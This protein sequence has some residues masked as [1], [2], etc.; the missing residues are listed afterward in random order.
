LSVPHVARA[1]GTLAGTQLIN[2]YGPT[3]NT[4]FTC[5]HRITAPLPLNCSIPVGRPV[6]NT[7]VYILD[8]HFQPVPI[9]VPG[10]LFIGG[11]GL[12]R[13]YLHRPKLTAEKFISD[14]FNSQSGACLYRTGD[15]VRW[16]PDGTIEFLGRID[17]QVKIRGFR[18]E[19]EEIEVVLAQNPE[20]KETVVLAREDHNRERQLVAYV[21]A[22]RQ[23]V[24]VISELR[25]FL[26]QKL[27]DYMVPSAFVFLDAL[28]L[29][30]NGKVDR[31][32]LPAP[33]PSREPVR[34]FTAP[35]DEVEN[36]LVGI[37]ET[38]LNVRPVGVHDNF[39]ELGGHSLAAVRLITQIGKSF[40]KNLPVAT[41][42]QTPTIERLAGLLRENRTSITCSS[43]VAIEPKGSKPP[44]FFIHGAGG[45]NLWTYAN[46]APHL[47]PDQPIYG[48]ESRGMR[49][50]E[51]FER[52]EEMAAH[53][54]EEI[55]TVQPRGPYYLG[56]YCFGGNVAY[57]VARQLRAQNE[58][59]ALLA[60][61]DSAPSN[62]GYG[63]I[64]WWRPS[65]VFNFA[66]NTFFWLTDFL[67]LKPDE[68]RN[69][70]H[71]KFRV[72]KKRV[73]LRMGRK[74]TEPQL[75]DLEDVIDVE[76]F[77]EIEL[78]LWNVHLRALRDYVSLPYP[79]RVTL[80]RTRGQPF[81]CSFDP[82][83]G[84][85]GLAAGGVDVVSIPGSHEKIFLEPHVRALARELKARL[86]AT[87]TRIQTQSH[88]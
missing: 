22:A 43:L 30:P 68:R 15:R 49:G 70:I 66:V 71:R 46:L 13:G 62:A 86:N 59:V 28:P 9:G 74:I 38:V 21:V 32:A 41:I 72:L 27:P 73:L 51:E 6:S 10:E 69:F 61:L 36:R 35:R 7:R 52:I 19:L 54:I 11:D 26:Q 23:P 2:G 12:A 4:T 77:P 44:V 18:I 67:E 34:V 80:F 78:K 45:G 29:N 60:L 84:W 63:R 64:P 5:C 53:Y 42:F 20:V 16:L 75:I 14:P 8:A 37:W 85:G 3:E 1:L 56:G 33:D 50:L 79:D 57:E 31:R 55:R 25:R 47:G 40:D 65:F 48:L 39:F 17:R 24:P 82:Q 81:L 58:T 83:F 76:R 88:L 87:Q